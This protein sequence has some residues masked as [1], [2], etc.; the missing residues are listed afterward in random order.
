MKRTL[1][2]L[3]LALMAACSSTRD[4]GAISSSTAPLTV[5]A[6]TWYPDSAPFNFQPGTVTTV[7]AA[8][9]DGLCPPFA[10]LPPTNILSIWEARPNAGTGNAQQIFKAITCPGNTSPVVPAQ[11]ITTTQTGFPPEWP[12]QGVPMFWVGQ[13]HLVPVGPAGWVAL[14]GLV[15]QGPF[16]ENLSGDTTAN[17]H[18]IGI[19]ISKDGGH[20]WDQASAHLV[21]PI[22][23][24]T[25]GWDDTSGVTIGSWN[26]T[27]ATWNGPNV[28]PI[29][30]VW[31][32]NLDG[33]WLATTVTYDGLGHGVTATPPVTVTSKPNL[34]EVS[35]VAGTHSVI[36]NFVFLIGPHTATLASTLCPHSVGKI[37]QTWQSFFSANAPI[38]QQWFSG[39]RVSA[40][41]W[42]C[43]GGSHSITTSIY[44][45]SQRAALGYDAVANEVIAATT[46]IRVNH[47]PNDLSQ[48]LAVRISGFSW[49]ACGGTC[50]CPTGAPGA[51]TASDV[52]ESTKG[53]VPITAIEDQINPLLA[54]DPGTGEGI[55]AWYD[56]AEN[57]ATDISSLHGQVQ[58]LTSTTLPGG[59]RLFF[60]QPIYPFENIQGFGDLGLYNGA[61]PLGDGVSFAAGFVD[62]NQQGQP[63]TNQ[64][65]IYTVTATP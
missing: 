9:T 1:L 62:G 40:S 57:A 26:V 32:T 59:L 2:V 58:P 37:A 15:G 30:V 61:T 14:V 19:V 56:T 42:R 16:G 4:Q 35:V 52:A 36:G 64:G 46:R 3:G 7:A 11:Q 21:A 34:T 50:N 5:G 22:D 10:S 25:G 44:P 51:G 6:T 49:C 45:T 29:F 53:D 60:P 33:S 8:S 39:A 13:P 38:G 55:V 65:G 63:P 43:A 12:D 47:D 41:T 31:S 48:S 18:N 24:L 54:A 27:A 23:G 20:T 28:N 17:A